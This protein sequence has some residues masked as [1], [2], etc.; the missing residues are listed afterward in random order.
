MYATINTGSQ[1]LI[2]DISEDDPKSISAEDRKKVILTIQQMERY[3]KYIMTH[4][5]VDTQTRQRCRG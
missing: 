1:Q 5:S 2:R 4:S 3:A